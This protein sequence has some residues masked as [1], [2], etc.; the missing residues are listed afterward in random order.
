ML[1]HKWYVVRKKARV[2]IAPHTT[3]MVST[4]A[5]KVHVKSFAYTTANNVVNPAMLFMITPPYICSS[6]KNKI[7]PY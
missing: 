2:P 5:E 7:S 3:K 1:V 6:R 4:S